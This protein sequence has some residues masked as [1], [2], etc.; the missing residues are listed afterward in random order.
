MS[1]CQD[2][3][4]WGNIQGVEWGRQCEHTGMFPG[5]TLWAV[6]RDNYIDL[7][8]EMLSSGPD[9][10][11]SSFSGSYTC[12]QPGQITPQNSCQP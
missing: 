2:T 3:R 9:S 7:P 10:I 4:R 6:W 12:R 11:N 1:N 8:P 5:E